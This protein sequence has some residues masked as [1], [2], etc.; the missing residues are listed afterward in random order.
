MLR[1]NLNKFFYLKFFI[2][3]FVLFFYFFSFFEQLLV[4]KK[5]YKT[6][7]KILIIFMLAFFL[8]FIVFFF[9]KKYFVIK[10][11]TKSLLFIY[12]S[13]FILFLNFFF[14][15]VFKKYFMA[16]DAS[17][18]LK[19]VF[20]V[21]FSA[22]FVCYFIIFFLFCFFFIYSSLVFDF[23]GV[24][25]VRYY[26]S[27]QEL[28]VF[29]VER[30]SEQNLLNRVSVADFYEIILNSGNNLVVFQNLLQTEI[31]SLNNSDQKYLTI[32]T[33]LKFF[34]DNK[35]STIVSLVSLGFLCYVG[36]TRGVFLEF[37]DKA[38]RDDLMLL[39]YEDM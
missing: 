8:V 4:I 6:K 19:G 33:W 31:D 36:Y 20:F 23:F 7:I 34:L 27:N 30:L 28:F 3:F 22:L 9:F 24:S 11:V 37:Y 39:M 13:I 32:K 1:F 21:C 18:M 2:F 25:I 26:W 35:T 29:G 14:F 12:L 15:Y 17:E 16:Q 10:I 5:E 38:I